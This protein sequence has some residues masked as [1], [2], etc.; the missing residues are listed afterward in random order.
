[1]VQPY[2]GVI[3]LAYD[4]FSLLS[5]YVKELSLTRLLAKIPAIS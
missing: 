1:M 3:V 4:N 2:Y 5:Q